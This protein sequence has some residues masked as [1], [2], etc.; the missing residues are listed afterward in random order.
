[1]DL[2]RRSPV[3]LFNMYSVKDMTFNPPVAP[4]G[5]KKKD[6]FVGGATLLDVELQR[7]AESAMTVI[8]EAELDFNTTH[9]QRHT[10]H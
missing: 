3:E 2:S 6:R 4:P 1:M 5:T 7:R 9:T 10:E 8:E